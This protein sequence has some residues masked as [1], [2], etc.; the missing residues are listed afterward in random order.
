MRG[1]THPQK[2]DVW[3]T[4]DEMEA[5]KERQALLRRIAPALVSL[6][7]FCRAKGLDDIAGI[8]DEALVTIDR[9]LTGQDF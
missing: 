2:Y 9:E 6:D 5:E 7:S 1:S 3:S 8:L 4:A